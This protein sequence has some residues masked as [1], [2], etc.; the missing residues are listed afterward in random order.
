VR[1]IVGRI[2]IDGDQP[3]AMVQPLRM[4]FDDA[5]G[6]RRA[7]AIKLARTNRV[8]E[9]R[10]RRLRSH[11]KSRNRIPV[12]QHLV[13]W[14]G[15]QSCRV[16]G[17][18]VTTANGEN[19]LRDEVIERVID[20]AGLPPVEQTVG[21]AGNQSVAPFGG[22]Q[23]HRTAIGGALPLVEFHHHRLIEDLWKQQTLCRVRISQAKA[24]QC[25]LNT[26]SSTCL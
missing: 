22:L 23:Q 21:Q 7:H 17:V 4:T 8:L 16:F 15:R 1:G 9:A 24:S 3:G 20:L 12:Q 13:H 18:G 26:V 11:I 10:Q 5:F 2:Q 6:L 25:A 14:V 19:A